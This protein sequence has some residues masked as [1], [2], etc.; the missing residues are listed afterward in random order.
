MLGITQKLDNSK[1]NTNWTN[2]SLKWVIF[3][4][5]RWRNWPQHV[6]L[7]SNLGCRKAIP[8]YELQAYLGTNVLP[9][10]YELCHCLGVNM[11]STQL[12]LYSTWNGSI[13][14][15]GSISTNFKYIRTLLIVSDNDEEAVEPLLLVYANCF[16]YIFLRS[17]RK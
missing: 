16:V 15:K 9:A 3:Y 10:I 1:A 17:T 7:C 8:T 11:Y 4:I 5:S 13:G 2:L 14:I 12:E 6:Q